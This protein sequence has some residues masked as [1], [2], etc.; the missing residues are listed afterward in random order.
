MAQTTHS[1]FNGIQENEIFE[2][3]LIVFSVGYASKDYLLHNAKLRLVSA[4]IFDD[5]LQ[6]QRQ[7]FA[8]PA[9][10]LPEMV[11]KVAQAETAMRVG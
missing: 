10:K 6:V 3:P 9:T 11:G 7:Q 5:L 2:I 1:F 4:E 8:A